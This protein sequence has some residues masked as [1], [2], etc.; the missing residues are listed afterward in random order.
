MT[1]YLKTEND[2][3]LR[4]ST[5][6]ALINKDIGALNNYKKTKEKEREIDRMK[7]TLASLETKVDLLL[8]LLNKR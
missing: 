6:N 2:K 1:I 5:S 3:L 4:D 7:S 8:E